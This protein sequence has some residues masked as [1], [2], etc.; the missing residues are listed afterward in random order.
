MA[1]AARLAGAVLAQ[2]HEALYLVGHP[3][4]P[5]DWAAH[6]IDPPGDIDARRRPFVRL[7]ARAAELAAPVLVLDVEGEALPQL[8]AQRFLIERT[9][10]I[11]ERLWRLT[12]G[13]SD[14]HERPVPDVVDARWLGQMPDPI[15]NIVREAV[16]RCS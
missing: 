8:L 10:S 1:R 3:K 9:G 16:L 5:C 7:H 4:A 14:E 11:S 12:L 13:E 15:W 6:G 2:T